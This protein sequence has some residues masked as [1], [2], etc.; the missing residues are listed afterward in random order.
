MRDHAFESLLVEHQRSLLLFI[1]SQV[2]NH[3]EAEDLLQRTNVILWQKRGNFEEGSNFRA[4]AFAIARLEMMN[5]LRQLQRDRK[6]F[7]DEEAGERVADATSR[8]AHGDETSLIALRDCLKRLPPRDRELLFVRYSTDRPLK[9]YAENLSRSPGT[10]K[11]RLHRI[12]ER[13][14]KSIMIRLRELEPT[15]AGG[16]VD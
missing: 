6:V 8:T 13:L 4:W 1:K 2:A 9:D 3:H 12:R 5:Q 16:A 15:M 10:L 14:R 7:T 11:A